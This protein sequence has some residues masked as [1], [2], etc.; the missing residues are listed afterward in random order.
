MA[1]PGDESRSARA[2]EVPAISVQADG[3]E[4]LYRSHGIRLSEQL[5]VVL[6]YPRCPVSPVAERIA[7]V[8]F[9]EKIGVQVA[10]DGP[11]E[12]RREGRLLKL[13]EEQ[14]SLDPQT[15]EPSL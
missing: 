5:L 15:R 14:F 7:P 2:W 10:A 11:V 4:Q 1:F 6:Q 3:F 12:K 8:P 13:L 9:V